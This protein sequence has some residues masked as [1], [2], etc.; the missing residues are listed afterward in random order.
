M[1]ELKVANVRALGLDT[2]AQRSL[3]PSQLYEE[4]APDSDEVHV[5]V[6]FVEVDE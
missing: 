1:R 2:F 3:V 4:E 5:F 6:V